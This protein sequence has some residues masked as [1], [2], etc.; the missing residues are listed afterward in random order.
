MNSVK[1]PQCGLINFAGEEK[2]KRCSADLTKVMQIVEQEQ[3]AKAAESRNPNLIPCADCNR[4]V[5]RHAE[6]CPQCGRFFQRF[7]QPIT[8]SR[9]GWSGTIAWGVILSWLLPILL[10]VAF[11]M[12]TGALIGG[13]AHRY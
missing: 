13:A 5:S 1:C 7:S 2:C 4:M 6:S 3:I 10:M 12:V 11:V 8:I 9:S